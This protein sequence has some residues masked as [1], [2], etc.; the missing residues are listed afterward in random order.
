MVPQPYRVNALVGPR[1]G[2]V[3]RVVLS[4]QPLCDLRIIML[5]AS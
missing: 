2:L 5:A 1:Y 4:T 3:R